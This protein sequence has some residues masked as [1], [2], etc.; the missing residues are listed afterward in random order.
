M[1]QNNYKGESNSQI[2]NRY[3]K[4]E[5]H[6]RSRI[7][8]LEWETHCPQGKHKASKLNT[9]ILIYKLT[10]TSRKI[11]NICQMVGCGLGQSMARLE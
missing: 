10:K 6:I 11:I 7:S 5:S 8:A 4:E 9:Q 2:N 1:V 3:D